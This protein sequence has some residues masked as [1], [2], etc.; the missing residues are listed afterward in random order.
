MSAERDGGAA[1]GADRHGAHAR[2]R[3]FRD[4]RAAFRRSP[5]LPATVLT[6]LVAAAAGLFAGSYTYAM[7]NPTPHRIPTAIAGAPASDSAHLRF[8]QGMEKALG[9]SLQ[10]RVYPTY[11]RAQEALAQ[12]REFAILRN[13]PAGVELDVAG[14][15]GASVAQLLAETAPKVG[16]ATGVTVAVRDVIPLQQGDPRGLALFYVSLAAVILG[17]V[18]AIQ[19]SVHA[20]ALNPAERI[21]FTVAYALLGGFTIAAVVD[22]VLGALRLPFT[23]SWLILALTMFT[24]GMVFTMFNTLI[25][26]WA[27]LPTWGLMVLLGNPSSGGAVSWPLLPSPLGTIGRWLPPGASVNAQHTAV[28]FRGHQH[29]FPFGVL[30]AWAAV[31]C[32]VFWVWRHRHP[33]GRTVLRAHAA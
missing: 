9:A 31:S 13:R 20:K 27:M 17:F 23:E 2:R 12:Q 3:A 30:L 19:L 22:W 18:G 25:G 26:R 7:A 24:S 16:A 21:A 32:A 28:Y 4:R 1:D 10:L 5:F 29:F 15:S 14:A 6:L 33:G 11:R 8:V